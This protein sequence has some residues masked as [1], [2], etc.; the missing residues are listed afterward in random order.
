LFAYYDASMLVLVSLLISFFA[1][2][3]FFVLSVWLFS[4][5]GFVR[6]HRSCTHW[7]P[8]V[9]FSLYIPVLYNSVIVVHFDEFT[10][11]EYI[12]IHNSLVQS[13]VQTSI[14][15]SARKL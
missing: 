1:S 9:L 3:F 6:G 14:R 10:F 12:L 15:D 11:N 7:S 2:L 13:S 4:R 8:F 5:I